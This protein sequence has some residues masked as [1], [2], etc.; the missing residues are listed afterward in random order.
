MAAD[1]GPHEPPPDPKATDLCHSMGRWCPRDTGLWTWAH[2]G[3]TAFLQR[4]S[5][6]PC[7]WGTTGTRRATTEAEAGEWRLR[8]LPEAGAGLVKGWRW[9]GAT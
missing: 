5:C 4:R 3:S 8:A 9:W 1:L 2:L 7:G 6:D